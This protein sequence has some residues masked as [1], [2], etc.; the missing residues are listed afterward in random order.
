MALLELLTTLL[1]PD[2]FPLYG[3]IK[4]CCG[5]VSDHNVAGS[6]TDLNLRVAQVAF[7]S[8]N[9]GD[10]AIKSFEDINGTLTAVVSEDNE[11]WQL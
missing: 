5:V 3:E 11:N 1:H 4:R 8:C 10:A 7:Q 9:L 6:H 2:A